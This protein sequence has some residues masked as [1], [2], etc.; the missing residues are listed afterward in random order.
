MA[1]ENRKKVNFVLGIDG[2]ATKTIARLID[3]ESGE[4]WQVC[5]GPSSLSHNFSDAIGI[6]E[7]LIKKLVSLSRC[8]LANVA[9]VFGLAGTE[10]TKLVASLQLV[11]ANRFA[12][13]DIC[14]DA[15]SSAY[16]ANGGAEVVAV[17]LGT[18]SVGMRL[19]CSE[20]G[21]LTHHLVGGWGFFIG[22]EGG[23]AK[24]GYH[25]VQTLVTEFQCFGYANSKLAQSIA[26]FICA[27][28]NTLSRH[29]ISDWLVL[30]QPI[31][32]A[33]LAPLVFQQQH[34]CSVAKKLLAEHAN[35]VQNLIDDTRAN[36]NLPVVLLGGLAQ[37]TM[38][39]L[40]KTTR[41]LLISSKGSAI[42]GAC[43]LAKQLI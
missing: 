37:L 21:E 6:L 15:K 2:G 13:F 8:E 1:L 18:G 22:D 26:T 31:D 40:S 17:A 3:I 10:N 23:G 20:S 28:V 36:T 9:V 33:Q 12:C 42:D 24:L 19:Q 30:A 4:Q 41:S 32:F 14:S 16:G 38:G 39:L 25:G 35:H 7:K 27:D 43:L 34:T 11:F 5:A 29:H